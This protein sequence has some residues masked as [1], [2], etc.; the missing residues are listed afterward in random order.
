MILQFAVVAQS[1]A[2]DRFTNRLSIF[3]V[4]ERIEA[5][6]FPIFVAE[7]VFVAVVRR[8]PNEPAVYDT[9]LHIRLGQTVIGQANLHIDF[10][11]SLNNRQVANFQ[12]LPIVTAGEL[13]FGFDLPNG[14]QV[15]A[16]VPVVQVPAPPQAR[17]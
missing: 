15:N 6:Q 14:V 4:C 8:E 13:Q 5:P 3:N 9:I 12:G 17:A 7:L 1:V 10:E 16:T 11:G 2:I